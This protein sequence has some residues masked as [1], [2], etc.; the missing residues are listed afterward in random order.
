MSHPPTSRH[1]RWLTIAAV[2]VVTA[3]AAAPAEAGTPV[4]E[5]TATAETPTLFDDAAGGD[6]SADD[7]AIWRDPDDPTRSL[8]LGTA[9]VGG[10][11]VYDLAARE[12]QSLPA[13]KAPGAGDKPGRINN[14]DVIEGTDLAVATDR[15]RDKLVVYSVDPGRGTGPV[16]DVTAQDSAPYIFSADQ[17]EVNKQA[18]AYGLASWKDRKT[19]RI[20]AVVTQETTN[21]VALLELTKEAGGTYGYRTIRTIGIPTAFTLPNGKRWAPCEDPGEQPYLEGMR[22]DPAN[23][24]LYA[25]QEDV[26]VWRMRADLTGEPTLI[27][28]VKDYGVPYTQDPGTGECVPGED[29]GFGGDHLVADVE[30][31]TLLERPGGGGYVVVSSQGDST[32]AMYDRDPAK[33]N[34]FVRSFRVVAGRGEGAIDGADGTDSLDIVNESFGGK[35][36]QGLAVIQDAPDTPTVDGD[37]GEPREG[38]NYKYVDL[39]N[40]SAAT[41]LGFR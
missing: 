5:V 26:G 3:A 18:T 31:I 4:A 41:G 14:V 27:D 35:Y 25:G 36:P 37:D 32:F 19:G 39:R 20:H 40:L 29:P 28:K 2:A 9:K 30:G 1:K 15:G 17:D 11:R 6:A 10:L 21:K 23:G 24:M 33:G 16:K 22:V 34:A 38:S 8:V 13:P 7:P 12:V